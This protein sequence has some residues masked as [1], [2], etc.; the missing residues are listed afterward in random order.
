MYI[1]RPDL[2]EE[3]IAAEVDRFAAVV[4][5][6]GGSEPTVEKW[7]KRRLAYEIDHFREGYYVVMNFQSEPHVSQELERMMRISDSVIRYLTVRK[8]D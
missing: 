7:G 4:T 1:I 2:E 6:N 5:N 8:D 3:A